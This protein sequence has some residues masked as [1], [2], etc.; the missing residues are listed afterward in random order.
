MSLC[1]IF[2]WGFRRANKQRGLNNLEGVITGIEKTLRNSGSGN[3]NKFCNSW[4][5]TKLQNVTI[6]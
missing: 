1:V 5:F 6:S 4:F 3:Q 2:V